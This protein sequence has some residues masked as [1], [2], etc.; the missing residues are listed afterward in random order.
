MEKTEEIRFGKHDRVTVMMA[1]ITEWKIYPMDCQE[2]VRSSLYKA[3]PLGMEIRLSE[4]APDESMRVFAVCYASDIQVAKREI[5]SCYLELH[6]RNLANLE[7]SLRNEKLYVGEIEDWRRLVDKESSKKKK[8]VWCHVKFGDFGFLVE[9]AV[10]NR[11]CERATIIIRKEDDGSFVGDCIEDRLIECKKGLLDHMIA[12]CKASTER[13]RKGAE[14][15][16]SLNDKAI[17]DYEE[18]KQNLE[19]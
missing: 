19:A 7:E 9:K 12:E 11:V 18:I 6:K 16:T 4:I 1:G 17:R 5:A 8:E 13:A 2:L 10:F 15:R 3:L 14:A